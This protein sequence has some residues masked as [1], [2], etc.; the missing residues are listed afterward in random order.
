MSIPFHL[1]EKQQ[2]ILKVTMQFFYNLVAQLAK[3]PPAMQEVDVLLKTGR[4][5]I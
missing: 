1:I 3:K 2:W 4:N 5:L